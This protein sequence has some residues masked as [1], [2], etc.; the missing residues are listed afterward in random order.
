MNKTLVI[1][2]TF[3]RFTT[4]FWFYSVLGQGY[5]LQKHIYCHY[6]FAD[7]NNSTLA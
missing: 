4:Y 6:L 7:M 2:L 1:T 5:S 3:T